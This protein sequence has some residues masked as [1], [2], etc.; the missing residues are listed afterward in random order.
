[1]CAPGWTEDRAHALRLVSPDQ[2]L[3]DA[4]ARRLERPL[5]LPTIAN[6]AGRSSASFSAPYPPI[7]NPAIARPLRELIVRH[8]A[9]TFA[10]KSVVMRGRQ[11]RCQGHQNNEGHGI[12]L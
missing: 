11:Q 8:F 12:G 7:D 3:Q 9:T 2:A 10:V 6:A 4:V 5:N 1:M